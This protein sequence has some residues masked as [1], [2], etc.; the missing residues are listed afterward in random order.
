V[1]RRARAVGRRRDAKRRFNTDR[2]TDRRPRPRQQRASTR[3]RRARAHVDAL[4]A[5]DRKARAASPSTRDRDTA[6]ARA[7][8]RRARD[9]RRRD[10]QPTNMLVKSDEERLRLEARAAAAAEPA[11]SPP[12]SPPKRD[13]WRDA[14]GHTHARASGRGRKGDDAAA[15]R[16]RDEAPIYALDRD[17]PNCDD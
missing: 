13:T 5:R 12:A 7:R 11:A 8:R 17:D 10:I 14:R 2:H 15:I 16:M 6:N 9:D 4:E 3:A 1:R